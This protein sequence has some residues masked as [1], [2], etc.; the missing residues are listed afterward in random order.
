[1]GLEKGKIYPGTSFDNLVKL[2]AE[3]GI[4]IRNTFSNFQKANEFP[5][6][7]PYDGHFSAA[8][9]KV[10]AEAIFEVLTTSYLP[11]NND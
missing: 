10:M 11:H 7:Y 5:L 8:G 3:S 9:N 2:G 6:F 4:D 1:Y